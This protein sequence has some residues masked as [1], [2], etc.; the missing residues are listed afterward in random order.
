MD[1]ALIDTSTYF[2]MLNAPRFPQAEWA[3][4]T[5]RHAL[6]YLEMYARFTISGVTVLEVTDGLKRKGKDSA[7]AR[8]LSQTLP[9]FD[10]LY[11]DQEV[12]ALAGEINA[13]LELAGNRIG[14][15]DCIIAATAIANRI[16]LITANP[17]HMERV[18]LAGY[19]LPILNWRED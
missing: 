16:T 11:P 2:D 5:R 9:E 14:S 13:N 8:F 4:S 10:V 1:R 18:A 6:A 7:I 19:P 12:M 15:V 3:L 17:R